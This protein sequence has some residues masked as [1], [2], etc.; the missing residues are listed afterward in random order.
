[1]KS[2]RDSISE[3]ENTKVNVVWQGFPSTLP[4]KKKKETLT[5]TN[6]FAKTKIQRLN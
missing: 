3:K 2:T 6:I 1:M 4:L 5:D